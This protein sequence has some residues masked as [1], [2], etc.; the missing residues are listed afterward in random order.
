MLYITKTKGL[1]TT[2][3]IKENKKETQNRSKKKIK[4]HKRDLHYNGIRVHLIKRLSV[5]PCPLY[6]SKQGEDLGGKDTTMMSLERFCAVHKLQS[7]D[8]RK[9]GIDRSIDREQRDKPAGGGGGGGAHPGGT[10]SL[11]ILRPKAGRRRCTTAVAKV[12]GDVFR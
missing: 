5:L 4:I 10:S 6:H 11:P 1:N 7:K 9:Q 8:R 2:N 12:A 3:Q